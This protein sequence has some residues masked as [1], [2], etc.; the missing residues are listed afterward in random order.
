MNKQKLKIDPKYNLGI[1]LIVLVI[2]IIVI[3]ILAGI[4][5][6]M[7]GG[8]NGILTKTV[9]A[10]QTNE[11]G[12]VEEKKRLLTHQAIVDK[13][14][15]K[16][17]SIQEIASK[18][19]SV[20][21]NATDGVISEIK[22]FN[23]NDAT[24]YLPIPK[25]MVYFD[26]TVNTG[27]IVIDSYG[28]EFVWVPIVEGAETTNSEIWSYPGTDPNK[29]NIT[30]NINDEYIEMVNSV[31]IYKGFY[32]GRYET[33]WTGTE[34]ASIGNVNPM[35][36]ETMIDG[37][38]TSNWYTFY[39]EIKKL[40]NDSVVSSMIYGSQWRAMMIWMND[41]INPNVEGNKKYIDNSKWMGNYSGPAIKTGTNDNYKVKNIYDLAGNMAEWTQDSSND[42][43]RLYYG[44]T[45]ESTSNA[46][47]KAVSKS[48]NR[49]PTN[50]DSSGSSRIALYIK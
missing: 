45:Y 26:G 34:V 47:N 38:H 4:A 32:V 16:T 29:K 30:D 43:Y 25:G 18:T 42:Q 23:E 49:S 15:E 6:S 41:I 35:N 13:Y 39:T 8:N 19:N 1:T 22:E 40:H 3:L 37:E 24:N 14:G 5:I 2:T 11:N 44:G 21:E 20:I 31:N 28:N 36:G 7:I 17:L 12:V 27:A 50:T 9:S 33:S 48:T 10:K 46:Y